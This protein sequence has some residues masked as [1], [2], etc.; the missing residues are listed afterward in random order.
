M[1]RI[2]YI[3]DMPGFIRAAIVEDGE[4][5][6]ILHERFAEADQ[7]ESLFY[8]RV[9]SIRPSV[10]AAFVDIGN[11]LNAFL[12]L[13][14]NMKLRCGDMLIVQGTAKQTT[15]TKGL[16][17]T[18]RI[19][20]AGKWL[21]LVPGGEGVHI[22]KKVK[23]ASQ[24]EELA[25]LGREICPEDCGLIIRTASEDATAELLGEEA[26]KLYMVWK[27]AKM[28]AA[29]MT[30]PGLIHRREPLY[31]RLVRDI[32]EISQIV[33]NSSAGYDELMRAKNSQLIDQQTQIEYFGE[34][35]A[36]IFDRF[37]IEPQIDKALKKRVWL[38]C[39]GYLVIDACEAMTVIDVNS[40]KMI[41]GKSIE[42]TALRVNLEAAE[43][44]AKQIR[45]R[46][47]N[48]IIIIDFIDMREDAHRKI[49]M[50]RIAAALAKDRSCTCVEGI[51][52]LGLMEITRKRVHTPLRK[53]LQ[54]SCS[55]C[56]GAG[57][58][59][60]AQEVARRALRQIRRF[61]IAGQRGPFIIRCAPAAA[62]ELTCL[63]Q[64]NINARVYALASNRHAEKFE[65]E[66]I[67]IDMLPPKEAVALK[68]GG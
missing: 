68:L 48:G 14:Q 50:E 4:L 9:Q 20:L 1:E 41:L 55:Y 56:S 64:M 7:T 53:S 57:E 13:E 39:G 66:Q 22:S 60:S 65:I 23:D 61:L 34:H 42:E 45:L 59:L 5:C 25:D 30:K 3:D 54:G 49:L 31:L 24:R 2:L 28:K 26:K 10:G 58:L 6:E 44:A 21:V 17:I 51:T 19:N 12:P 18:S 46:D 29:G 52:R 32:R 16:R 27:T 38:P 35:D 36:L 67:G 33:I 8:G 15:E 43:E 62:Q 63:P 37:R 11:E 40:G 47:M